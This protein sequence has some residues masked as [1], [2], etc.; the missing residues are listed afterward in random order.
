MRGSATP[1]SEW[2]CGPQLEAAARYVATVRRSTGL[3]RL[4]SAAS[5]EGMAALATLLHRLPV[6]RA[7]FS[8]SPSGR[9]LRSWFGA[10]RALPVD[11]APVALLRL[12]GTPDEYLRGRPRQALR[13]NIARA[14]KAG[15]TCAVVRD[16]AEVRRA[17]VLIAAHRGQ[18]PDEMVGL[19]GGPG[20]VRET[21][22]AYDAVGDPVGMSVMVLDGPWAGLRACVTSPGHQ[23]AL[24]VRY[25]L[26]SQTAAH[27]I[28]R[29]VSWLTVGG[30]MLLSSEGT[31]YFQRRTGFTP[32]WL[33][34][35][36]PGRGC[37]PAPE[38]TPDA[39]LPRTHDR[40]VAVLPSV[41][42]GG[43]RRGSGAVVAS[44]HSPGPR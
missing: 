42:F 6:V 27:L 16:P 31:R 36:A 24:A 4:R 44:S 32:V 19:S 9:E 17:A 3:L 12:P 28:A 22:L 18:C 33:R 25:L 34:P 35:G 29:E 43:G 26:Q 40:R 14:R 39:T 20:V 38:L 11:R 41:A 1:S 21:C 5:L 7:E 2:P 37:D 13:T 15:V 30:S 8:D 10:T 23:D